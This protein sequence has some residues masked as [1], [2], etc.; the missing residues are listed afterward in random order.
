MKPLECRGCRFQ[1]A[2]AAG[3]VPDGEEQIKLRPAR[4]SEPVALGN[5]LKQAEVEVRL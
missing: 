1:A 2:S 3:P 5:Q 4:F